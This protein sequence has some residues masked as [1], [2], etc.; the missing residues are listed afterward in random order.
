MANPAFKTRLSAPSARLEA[1]AAHALE[2]RRGRAQIAAAPAAS[3][4]TAA[5]I[6]TMIKDGAATLADLQ[7]AWPEIVGARLA[8]LTAP[9]KL[10]RAEGVLTVVAHASAAPF[11]QHQQSLIVERANLA[12]AA[13]KRVAIRQGAL[14][15][16]ASNV[17]PAVRPLAPEEEVALAAALGGVASESLRAALLR[18]GRAVAAK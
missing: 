5:L 3:R 9:E 10:Q 17:R 8:A 13:I 6:R 14:P 11:V 7:R 18:L 15:A 16:R 2:S 1:A 12:G 4:F